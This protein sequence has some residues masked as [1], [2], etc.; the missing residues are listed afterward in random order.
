MVLE[1]GVQFSAPRLNGAALPGW[2]MMRSSG[3]KHLALDFGNRIVG[4]DKLSGLARNTQA[5][6]RQIESENPFAP[7]CRGEQLG[8]AI[9]GTDELDRMGHAGRADGCRQRNGG[10]ADRR[11]GR[12]KPRIAG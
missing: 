12:A 8:I 9:V 6:G 1:S 5:T 10:N 2:I 11:P 7:I 4:R 3:I